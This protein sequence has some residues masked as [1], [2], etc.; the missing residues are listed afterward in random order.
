MDLNGD[1]ITDILSGSYPGEMVLF[2]GKD[3][4]SFGAAVK[5]KDEAGKD[6]KVGSAAAPHAFDWDGDGDLDLLVGNIEGQV[7]FVQNVGDAREPVF[8]KTG[9]LDVDGAPIRVPGGNA[10]PWIAD[11]DGDGVKDL[12]VGC[13]DGSVRL[14]AAKRTPGLPE[15]T[16][17]VE[18]VAA[19]AWGSEPGKKV[20]RGVRA[21]VCVADWNGDGRD[22]LLV[23][24]FVSGQT[25][26]PDLTDSQR[27]QR[28]RAQKA[29]LEIG[30]K[31]AAMQAAATAEI[32]AEGKI[33]EARA[34]AQEAYLR[35]GQ[36]AEYQ[37]LSEKHQ[38]AWRVV[39]KYSGKHVTGGFVRVH[40]RSAPAE[41]GSK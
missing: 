14:Y 9:T 26:P 20:E 37:T 35:V 7:W 25:E 21:K 41:G 12:V 19:G 18:L 16:K 27:E 31:M 28:D 32:R 23:G 29:Q 6:V 5:L 39:Q 22:D 8:K 40:L 2:P 38:A 17:P 3:D 30:Q 11:W 4:G 33:T 24:D 10:G 13:G 15:L 1:G 36:K 34:V